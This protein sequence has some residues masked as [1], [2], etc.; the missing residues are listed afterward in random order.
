MTIGTRPAAGFSLVDG[1]WLR[2]LSNGNNDTFTSGIVAHAGGT[3]AA[4]VLLSNNFSLYEIDT[5]VSN[6]DSVVLPFA[7]AGARKMIFNNGAS[8]LAIYA[9][10]NNN[11]LTGSA[12]VINKTSNSSSY[13]ITSGQTVLFWC[14]KNGIWAANKTA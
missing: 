5:V 11:P 10:P 13:T 2:E 4:G 3:Q 14:A 6:N 9:N 12:D 1:Q 7:G 8:T